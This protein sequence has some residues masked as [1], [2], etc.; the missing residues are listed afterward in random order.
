VDVAGFFAVV[1]GRLAVLEDVNLVDCVGFLERM[2]TGFLLTCVVLVDGLGA[3]DHCVVLE[4][5][6][7]RDV[8]KK[9]PI[10]FLSRRNLLP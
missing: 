1:M 8:V 7:N 4:V 10:G 3:V 5:G 6:V 2:V 9:T